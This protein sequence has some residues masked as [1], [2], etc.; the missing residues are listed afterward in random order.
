M[1]Y[2]DIGIIVL[3][4]LTMWLLHKVTKD[5]QAYAAAKRRYVLRQARS[6]ARVEEPAGGRHTHR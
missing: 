3:A 6:E 5:T 4:V 1:E 2:V